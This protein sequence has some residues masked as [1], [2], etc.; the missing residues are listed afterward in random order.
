L[1]NLSYQSFDIT[2]LVSDI[3]AVLGPAE[4]AIEVRVAG[5]VTVEADADRLRQAIENLITNALKHSPQGVPVVVEVSS[6]TRMD[7]QWAVVTV[8]DA[9]PGVPPDL[10]PQLFTRF[11]R[12]PQSR[13]LGLGLYLAHSIAQAHGG[14]LTVESTPGAGAVFTLAIPNEPQRR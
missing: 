1:F 6:E 12:G 3:A 14:T 4:S 5:Q 2:A 8:R 7:G 11:V 13:G 9:G 10:L